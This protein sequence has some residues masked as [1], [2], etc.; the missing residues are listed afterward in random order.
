MSSGFMPSS[1]N[2]RQ[3]EKTEESSSRAVEY[4]LVVQVPGAN[5]SDS[6]PKHSNRPVSSR[7]PFSSAK[8]G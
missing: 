1:R 7:L 4:L 6:P 3:V 8:P 5:P 2:A